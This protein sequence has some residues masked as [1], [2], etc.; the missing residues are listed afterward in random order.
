M[1][2]NASAYKATTLAEV[3]YKMLTE[4][5]EDLNY[6]E[7]S[8]LC[9]EVYQNCAAVQSALNGNNG[10]LGLAMPIVQYTARTGG[11]AYVDSPSSPGA[12]DATI[13]NNAGQ[14]MLSHREAEHKQ[15]VDNH[16]IKKAVKNIIKIMLDEVLP[17]WL[18][19]KI[20][21]RETGLNTVSIHNILDHA[22]DCRGQ[23]DKRSVVIFLRM[24]SNPSQTPNSLQKANSMPDKQASSRTNYK[25]LNKLT[26]HEAG[27]GANTTVEQAQS[28]M[29][30]L[31][32]TMDNLAYATTA[33]NIILGQLTDTNTKL[34]QQLADAMKII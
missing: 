33:S 27:F 32:E 13:A 7:L 29:S 9:Q 17:H 23:I 16:M 1:S 14:V 24:Q 30:E 15:C 5:S 8:K 31:E 19:A 18:L 26:S 4:V 21:D 11:V 6:I 22:F 28:N 3:P 20:E 2:T 10:H 34:T 25:M 12:Y